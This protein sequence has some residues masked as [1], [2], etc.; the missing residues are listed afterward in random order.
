MDRRHIQYLTRWWTR[1]ISL[2][3]GEFTIHIF[4][5]KQYG[6]KGWGVKNPNGGTT[7]L[8]DTRHRA[9]TLAELELVALATLATNG[10]S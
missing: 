10:A 8:A 2:K 7:L 9:V 1:R 5:V 4:P 3:L 6:W